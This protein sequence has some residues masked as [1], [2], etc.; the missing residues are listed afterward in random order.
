VRKPAAALVLALAPT[1]ALSQ[2]AGPA[3]VVNS[4]T[5]SDQMG[6]SVASDGE[7]NFV[8]VWTSYDQDGDSRGVFGQRF[9]ATAVPQGGEFRVNSYTTGSQ[10]VAR[11]AS[12]ANG[13]VVVIWWGADQDGDGLGVFAQRFDAF[14]D[15]QGQEFRVNTYTTGDQAGA[16]VASDASGN[17]V[18]VWARDYETFFGESVVG[19]R[20]DAAGT[21]QGGEFAVGSSA[22]Q[23]QPAVAMDASGDFV[24]VWVSLDQNGRSRGVL[25]QR[26]SASGA[27]QG[28]EL[29]IGSVQ[30]EQLDWRPSVSSD[31]DGNFVVVWTKIL[32]T[33]SHFEVVGQRYDASGTAQGGEFQVN[34]Y[35]TDMQQ[36]AV[37]T[38]E[39]S[40]AFVVVWMS[41]YQDGDDQGVFGQRYDASGVPLGVEFRVNAYTTHTQAFPAIAPSVDGKFV[42]TWHGNGPGATPYDV[43][44][45]VFAG[46]VIFKDGFE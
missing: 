27:A 25:G 2:V 39:E 17:F 24:V 33:Q 15:A 18:V 14:G 13:N 35:T 41:K 38:V 23:M 31:P 37:V 4:Y 40:G 29:Q 43:F 21:P 12:D 8:V 7:G 3:F 6:P 16:A 28:P 1:L 44:G 10:A 9:D 19:Q 46:D 32:L 11:V 26:Y 45:A 5:T 30:T 42:V 36:E 22:A 34:S 20:Y